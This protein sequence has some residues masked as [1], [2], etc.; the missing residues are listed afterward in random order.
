MARVDRR[1]R[2]VILYKIMCKILLEKTKPF[3]LQYG[4]IL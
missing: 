3:A 4:I 1:H 2:L